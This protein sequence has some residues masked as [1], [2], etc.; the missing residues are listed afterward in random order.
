VS[1]GKS[2][3][4][5]ISYLHD[6][7][8]NF[9]QSLAICFE[10]FSFGEIIYS[11]IAD[12]RAPPVRRRVRQRAAAAWPPHPRHP[13]H[14]CHRRPDCSPR[15]RRRPD[16]RGLKPPTPGSVAVSHRRL[17]ADEPP[18]PTV[19]HA[20]APCRRRLTKQRRRRAARRR[21][22][23]PCAARCTGRPS[24]AVPAPRTRAAPRT[25]HQGRAWFR[26]I[27]TRLNF[28]IF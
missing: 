23:A 22:L 6:F 2:V 18:F 12:E 5:L 3:P 1:I 24:W 20:S 26:P 4:N 27:G 13:P 16:R 8:K 17:H 25:V 15:S 11:K 7:F 28:I 21:A 19:S 14:A 10:L 9:S